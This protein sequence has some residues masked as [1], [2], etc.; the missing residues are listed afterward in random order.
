MTL[1]IKS[2]LSGL[3]SINFSST[4]LA[5]PA[6][7]L[8]LPAF[9]RNHYRVS[10]NHVTRFTFF[11]HEDYIPRFALVRGLLEFNRGAAFSF[12]YNK[13][14]ASF[15]VEVRTA[16]VAALLDLLAIVNSQLEREL[17]FK[18]ALREVIAFEKEYRIRKAKVYGG[19]MLG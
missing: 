3:S 6:F 9:I 4:K 17:T 19:L 10:E 8:T 1:A 15:D 14:S 12:V 18:S 2:P 11:V 5:S 13:A 16:D 7:A